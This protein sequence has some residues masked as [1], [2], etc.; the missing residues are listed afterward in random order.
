VSLLPPG[1]SQNERLAYQND[2]TLDEIHPAAVPD[3]FFFEGI[4]L[5]PMARLLLEQAWNWNLFH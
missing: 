5:T 4:L 1:A 2:M 3:S